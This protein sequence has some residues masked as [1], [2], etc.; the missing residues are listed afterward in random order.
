MTPQFFPQGLR[1]NEDAGADAYLENL[2]T[3]VV[4]RP[5]IDSVVN[6][7]RPYVSQ[8][9][10]ASSHKALK[11]QEWMSENFHHHRGVVEKVVHKH[12]HNTNSSLMEAIARAI[13]DINK[14][15]LIKARS[16]SL[17]ELN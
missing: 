12:L 5:W 13:E 16:Q 10:S 4:K 7:G 17:S 2:Q 14:D 15:H 6:G 3:I 8:P 11:T 9:D 1:V